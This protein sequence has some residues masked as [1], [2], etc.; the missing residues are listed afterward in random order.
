MGMQSFRQNEN[1]QY[2]DN[3]K[4][5]VTAIASVTTTGVRTEW[6]KETVSLVS[7]RVFSLDDVLLA[8]WAGEGSVAFK[9][10]SWMLG[11]GEY[12][13]FHEKDRV[14]TEEERQSGFKV[15]PNGFY[16]V[17]VFKHDGKCNGKYNGERED[18]DNKAH[19]SPSLPTPTPPKQPDLL[20]ALVKA[21]QAKKEPKFRR[22]LFVPHSDD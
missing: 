21:K 20:S 8:I 5:H 9:V 18:K 6:D 10:R 15:H 14:L 13:F 3:T 1:T 17:D 16:R 19:S 7:S 4:P 2:R 22:I 12:W 11:E